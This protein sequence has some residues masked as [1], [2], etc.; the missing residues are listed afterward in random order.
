MSSWAMHPLPLLSRKSLPNTS[1]FRFIQRRG[2]SHVGSVASCIDIIRQGR[3]SLVTTIEIYKI[4]ALNCLV[5]A[6]VLS[7]RETPV[8]FEKNINISHMSSSLMALNSATHK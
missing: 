6:F 8:I 7:V 4:I 1:R 2:R 3:G 5:N